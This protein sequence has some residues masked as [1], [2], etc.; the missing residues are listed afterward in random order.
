MKAKKHDL[1]PLYIIS[2]AEMLV[3]GIMIFMTGRYEA[4]DTVTYFNAWDRLLSGMPDP[5]RT[6]VYPLIAGSL[7]AVFGSGGGAVVLCLA[8][9]ALFLCSIRWF[10]RLTEALTGNATVAF[11]ATA[12]YA[13]YPGPLT[14][15]CILLTESLSL[16]AMT[17]LLWLSYL[18]FKHNNTKAAS[19]AGAI[20]CALVLLRPALIFVPLL[21]GLFWLIALI[22]RKCSTRTALIS[23]GGC[24]AAL[25][26]LGGYC[27][28][29]KS[30]H[31]IAGPS[32]VTA[33]NNY[34]TVREAGVIDS[35]QIDEPLLRRT[36]DSILTVRPAPGTIEETWTELSAINTNATPAQIAAFTTG[37]MKARPVATARYILTDRMARA[38]SDDAVYGG[39]LFP[40]VRALT[41][42]IGVNIGA[43]LALM[44]VFITIML[45][46][47]KFTPYKWLIT[48]LFAATVATSIIGAQNEWQRL[49]L[50]AYPALLLMAAATL[51]HSA[52]VITRNQ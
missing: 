2:A 16:S 11:W 39:S 41:K 7:R 47:R 32:S 35:R 49:I 50:P 31:G 1:R 21:F 36:V 33:I 29:M 25:A 51:T 34:F 37:A 9:C 10:A 38:V 6:P 3:F 5:L 13:V 45:R 48:L 43:A 14:L 17:G 27:L 4:G 26:L 52:T 20:T 15:N 8:Q 18:A 30:I 22:A 24:V 42:L 28:L 44:L 19:G 12:I 23:M 40:P 46:S